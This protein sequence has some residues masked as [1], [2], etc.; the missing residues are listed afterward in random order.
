MTGP[1]GRRLSEALGREVLDLRPVAGGDL[2]EAYSAR[3]AGGEEVFVKTRAGAAPGEFAT[4]AEGLRW[5]AA[6]GA[7]RVA[8]VLAVGEDWLA[9]RW[10]AVGRLDA[11]GQEELGRGLAQLHRAGA[12]AFG[13]TRPLRLGPLELPN[14]PS[15]HWPSFYAGRRLLPLAGRAGLDRVVGRVC[16]RLDDLVGPAEPPARLHGDLWSGNVLAGRD[17]RPWLIDP[18][19]YGGHREVDLAMLALFGTPAPR[20]LAAYDE[21]WPRAAGHQDRLALYQL[22]PLLVHAVLFGGSYVRAAEA[23]ARRYV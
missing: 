23:A 11:A 14:D 5:L 17:G 10:I 12:P 6:A 8:E 4:E 16:E 2:N 19:A 3:L 1:L 13:G 18:A 15:P 21:V 9:L 22:F 7:L 20:T